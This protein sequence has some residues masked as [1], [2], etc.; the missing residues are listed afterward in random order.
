MAYD[1]V[2]LIVPTGFGVILALILTWSQNF[3]NQRSMRKKFSKVFSFELE[4]LKHD[5]DLA[6]RR[7]DHHESQLRDLPDGLDVE[8]CK[9]NFPELGIEYPDEALR[10]HYFQSKYTFLH[11]NHE[12]IFVFREDTIKSIIKISSLMEEYDTLSRSN[13][14][15]FLDNNLRTIQKEIPIALE[16]L[17]K[18]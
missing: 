5:L 11:R 3:W 18:E 7:Y 2:E 13:E 8:D 6:I 15:I 14:K 4:Q 10:G 17:K 9:E 16:L 1:F 12:K